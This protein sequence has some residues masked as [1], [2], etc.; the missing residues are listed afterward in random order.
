MEERT[1]STLESK[2][3]SEV[4]FWGYDQKAGRLVA[5]DFLPDRV[6]TKHV[7]GWRN[8]NFLA[9][10]DDPAYT[11]VLN[12]NSSSMKWVTG[13]ADGSNIVESCKR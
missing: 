7:Q 1:T 13:Y 4:Q 2:T 12:G 3:T 6:M 11:V 5:Y 8:G 10:N 9:T